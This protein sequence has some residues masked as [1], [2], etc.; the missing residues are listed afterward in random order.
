MEERTDTATSSAMDVVPRIMCSPRSTVVEELFLNYF[1]QE[2]SLFDLD[3]LE[4]CAAKCGVRGFDK[5]RADPEHLA[6][7]VR[8]LLNAPHMQRVG[9][10]PYFIAE[11]SGADEEVL[12]Q[13][14]SGAQSSA[15][16]QRLFEDMLANLAEQRQPQ[17]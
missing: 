2:Q 4:I 1:E 12:C 5:F 8:V 14:V 7:P 9:R 10:V 17:G 13:E 6:D 16:F 15:D 11:I 3:V